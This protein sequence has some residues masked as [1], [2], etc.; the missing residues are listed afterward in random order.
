MNIDDL[1]GAWGKDEPAGMHLPQAG[2]ILG[3]TTSAVQKIRK[4]M[5]TELIYTA[6]S[7]IAII[8]YIVFMGTRFRS[9]QQGTFFLNAISVLLFTLLLLNGYFFG[10]FYLFY[11]S[12]GRYDL[13]ALESV[14]KIAYELELNTEIYKTYSISVMPLAVLITFTMA[15]GKHI[16]DYLLHIL[17]ST[18]LTSGGMLW[19][20][21]TIL[22]GFAVTWYFVN[23][24]VKL[25]YGKY[26][27]ELKQIVEDLG[28]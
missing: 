16:Y 8:G 21:A 7:Y 14:R 9:T 28:E 19:V 12:A 22:I 23:L 26:L 25:Q 3:K 1:K 4:K 5:R 15:G 17:A 27:A 6:I 2:A 10:R 13:A 24:H 18:D 11:K 20:F